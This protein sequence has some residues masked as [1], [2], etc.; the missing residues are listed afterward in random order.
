MNDMCYY[1]VHTNLEKIFRQN[2]DK[3]EPLKFIPS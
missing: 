1:G 3:S 2:N